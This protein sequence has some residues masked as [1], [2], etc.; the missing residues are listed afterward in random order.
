MLQIEELGVTIVNLCN[1]V[2]DGVVCFFPSYA[3]EEKVYN[4]WQQKGIIQRIEAK[5]LVSSSIQ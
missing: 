3:Y 4:H 5:K 2:P 1:I